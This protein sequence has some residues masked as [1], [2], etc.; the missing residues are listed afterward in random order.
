[1]AFTVGELVGY[2]K[3]D[4]TGWNRGLGRAKDSMEDAGRGGVKA[5]GFL[6]DY[7]TGQ[8]KSSGESILTLTKYFA[9]F[10]GVAAGAGVAA[11]GALAA[12]PLI[13]AGVAAGFL[14]DN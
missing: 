10:G 1:M 9:I 6:G 3:L 12:L 7:I 8:A 13:F 4:E 5:F 11:G 14:K 2:L